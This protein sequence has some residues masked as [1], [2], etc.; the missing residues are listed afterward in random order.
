MT[1]EKT[2]KV[3]VVVSSVGGAGK[4]EL[5]KRGEGGKKRGGKKKKRD[6]GMKYGD[7]ERLG[8]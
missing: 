7:K 8:K 4:G 5:R 6:K 1:K 2:K 3:E